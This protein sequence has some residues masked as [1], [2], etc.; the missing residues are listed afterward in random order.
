MQT[1]GE[2]GTNNLVMIGFR[3]GQVE[4]RICVEGQPHY[5]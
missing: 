5:K 3:L 2:R 4:G 1:F